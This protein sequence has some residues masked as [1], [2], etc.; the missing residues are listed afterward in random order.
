MENSKNVIIWLVAG[1]VFCV[2]VVMIGIGSSFLVDSKPA[3]PTCETSPC[4]SPTSCEVENCGGTDGSFDVQ[5]D[6][7]HLRVNCL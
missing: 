7:F 5:F 6:E 4:E 3:P 1:I 2:G